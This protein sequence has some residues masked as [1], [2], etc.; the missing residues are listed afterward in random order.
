MTPSLSLPGAARPVR[1]RLGQAM[2]RLALPTNTT[3]PL[4]GPVESRRSINRTGASDLAGR[5]RYYKQFK[6]RG[7][8]ADDDEL[9]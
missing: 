5:P 1:R 6:P 4:I 7:A 8:S 2:V 3:E 9:A